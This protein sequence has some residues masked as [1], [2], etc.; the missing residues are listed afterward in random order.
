MRISIDAHT[1]T[2]DDLPDEW[3][4]DGLSMTAWAVNIS[5]DYTDFEPRV[6][7]TVEEIGHPGGGLTA[8]LPPPVALRLRAALGTALSQL[9]QPAD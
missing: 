4:Q 5:D 7:L 8:H 2:T 6:T 3:E 9:G 1:G